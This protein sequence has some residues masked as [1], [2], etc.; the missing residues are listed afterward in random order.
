MK[1]F[2]KIIWSK[3]EPV[4]KNDIWFDGSTFRAYIEGSWEIIIQNNGGE[5]IDSETIEGFIP[6]MREFSDDFNNDFSR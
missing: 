3:K 5:P 1:I 2:N 4:N 6:L